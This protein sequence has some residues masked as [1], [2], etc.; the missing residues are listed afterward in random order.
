MKIKILIGTMLILISFSSFS[1]A[2]DYFGVN[3]WKK[4]APESNIK[5]NWVTKLSVNNITPSIKKLLA[6]KASA[7]SNNYYKYTNE[8]KIIWGI[9]QNENSAVVYYS[10]INRRYEIKSGKTKSD[11]KSEQ[12]SFI[13]FQSGYWFNKYQWEYVVIT[14]PLSK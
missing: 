6:T 1:N 9:H 8:L 14:E 4:L 10:Y 5:I 7:S 3:Q 13:R 2:E 11:S 12:S